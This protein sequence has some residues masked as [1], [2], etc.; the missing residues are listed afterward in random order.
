MHFAAFASVPESVADPAKYYRNNVV[1]TP[2]PARRHAGRR[3][4]GGSSS[5]APPPSTACPNASRSPRT[6]PT[7]RS[8]P[9]ASRSSPIERAL[10]DY[11]RAYGLGYAALRYFNACGAAADGTIGEDHDPETHLIPL[12]PPGRPRPARERARSSAPTTRRPTA[13][14]SATTS[15]SRTWPTPTSAPWSGSRPGRGLIYNVGTG[16]RLQRPRGDRR[17]AAASPAGR[18][19]SRRAPRRAGDPPALVAS[20]EAIRR[21]LGWSPRYVEIDAVIQSAWKWHSRI[22]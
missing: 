13:P 18:F 2:E 14:A 1:G 6:A 15:T 22:Q 19:P 21:D 11:A 17:R 4:S 5:P 3:A 20:S 10:A 12:D 16:V 9:T 8:I 7:R